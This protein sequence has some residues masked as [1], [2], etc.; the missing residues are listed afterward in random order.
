MSTS[1]KTYIDCAFQMSPS[2]QVMCPCDLGDSR[3]SDNL[4]SSAI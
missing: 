1:F 2:M 4:K 3:N